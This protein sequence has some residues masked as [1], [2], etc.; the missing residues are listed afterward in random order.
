[1]TASEL[2][3]VEEFRIMDFDLDT[4]RNVVRL[5]YGF[6]DSHRFEEVIHLGGPPL[7]GRAG[8]GIEEALRLLHLAAGVSYFKAGAPGRISVETGTMSTLE[9]AFVR[10]L[11]DK[12]MREFAVTNG[13]TVPLSL[14]I[15]SGPAHR[16]AA[17][18]CRGAHRR[19]QGLHR[20]HR[21]A[22]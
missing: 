3:R 22:S 15:S 18:G 9:G 12:G 21:G 17:R 8:E 5:R 19:R 14:E 2:E 13:L 16:P 20:G 4:D 10:D 11:Y 7:G 6:D 1:L